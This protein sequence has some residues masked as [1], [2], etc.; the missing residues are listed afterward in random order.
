MG[1][2]AMLWVSRDSLLRGQQESVVQTASV[3]GP[4]E[5]G[6]LEVLELGPAARRNLALVTQAARTTEYWRT[7]SIPAIVQD[8]PGISDRGVTSPAVGVV[9][10]IH[11]YPGDTVRSGERLATLQLFSEYLQAT[12]TQL[13]KATQEI[14]LLRSEIDRLSKLATTGAVSQTRIIE[15]QNDVNRQQ[16]T[17]QAARQELVTRGLS[18]YQIDEISRGRFVSSLDLVAPPPRAAEPFA[19]AGPGQQNVSADI[20]A[21]SKKANGEAAMAYEVQS[22]AVELGQ[23]VQAGDLVAHLANHQSLFVV[24]HAFKRESS[25]L[26]KAALEAR[27]VEIEFTDDQSKLWPPLEQTFRIRHLSN[28]IDPQSRTF[29]FFLTLANQSRTYAVDGMTFMVWRFRPGQ[30]AHV[31]VPI[32][33]MSNVFVLPT[34][35]VAREGPTAYVYQQNGDLFHQIPVHILYEDRRHIV[36]ARDGGITPGTY[37]AQNAAASLRRVLKAQSASGEQPGFHVHADGTVHGA[38]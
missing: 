9:S 29:D 35:A 16:T 8:R 11:V 17:I 13:F 38:H 32:E 7:I 21:D 36:I 4:V 19:E 6:A 1:A 15:L 37:L 10:E 22:L 33:R 3:P 14:T 25:A 24:G 18:S 28:A 12:Q 5:D 2:A 27:P 23:T 34:D 20:A 31:H 30:R 26:E